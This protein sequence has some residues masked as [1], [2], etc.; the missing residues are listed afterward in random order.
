MVGVGGSRTRPVLRRADE[1]PGAGV[2]SFSSDL[3]LVAFAPAAKPENHGDVG[4][5]EA[6]DRPL[7]S[8]GPYLSPLS[9]EA[10]W[11]DHLRQEPS[12]LVALAGIRGGGV[13]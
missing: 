9:S 13:Q 1:W 7:D 10:T 4:A 2:V 8:S 5:D 11:R 12:A 6:L 3:A